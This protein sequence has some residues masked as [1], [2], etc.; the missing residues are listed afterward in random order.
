MPTKYVEEPTYNYVEYKALAEYIYN[1]VHPMV[2]DTRL[3]TLT[4]PFAVWRGI[5]L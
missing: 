2:A 3:F 1:A 4:S 5:P